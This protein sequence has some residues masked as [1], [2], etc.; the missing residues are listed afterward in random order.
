MT[1]RDSLD[2]YAAAGFKTAFEHPGLCKHLWIKNVARRVLEDC[3]G[4]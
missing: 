3:A 1:L 2:Y 4:E